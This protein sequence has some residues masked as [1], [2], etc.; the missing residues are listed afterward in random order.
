VHLAKYGARVTTIVRGESLSSSMSTYLI[1]KIAN[2]P[3]IDVR[4]RCEVVDGAGEDHLESVTLRDNH[5][6]ACEARRASALSVVNRRPVGS[7]AWCSA[8]VPATS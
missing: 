5:T 8:T 4:V 2:T 6:G 3:A 1:H 7:M